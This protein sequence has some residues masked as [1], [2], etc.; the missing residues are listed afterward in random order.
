MNN[1]IKTEESSGELSPPKKHSPAIPFNIYTYYSRIYAPLN[2]YTHYNEVH[3][4]ET[5]PNMDNRI[6]AMDNI[7]DIV[8]YLQYE[9]EIHNYII[10]RLKKKKIHLKDHRELDTNFSL[11]CFYE[12]GLLIYE[13]ELCTKFERI[14]GYIKER[15]ESYKC[16]NERTE[17]LICEIKKHHKF[18]EALKEKHMFPLDRKAFSLIETQRISTDNLLAFY[19]TIVDIYIDCIKKSP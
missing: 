18:I 14:K 19:V 16:Q 17:W 8:E 2:C 15:S 7:A 9:I 11:I 5:M 12:T 6:K 4:S 10:E 13:Y 1:E 3:Y